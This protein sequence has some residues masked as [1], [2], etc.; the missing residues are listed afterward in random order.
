MSDRP[1]LP[2]DD[3]A[4]PLWS[5]ERLRT[6]R[7][8]LPRGSRLEHFPLRRKLKNYSTRDFQADL[9]AGS[10]VAL[11]DF[12]QGMAYALIA[13]LPFQHG[14]YAS[15]I[16]AV[17]GPL[18]A[19]SRFLMLGP[20]NAIAVLSLSAFMGL[21]F[22][23]DEVL[24]AMPLLLV[25]VG[26]ILIA[27]AFAGAAKLIRYVSRS[28]VTG[29]IT[30]A[31]FLIIGNQLRHVLGYSIP[32]ASTFLE[33]VR[34]TVGALSDTRWPSVALAAGALLLY[35]L[36]TRHARALPAV[37]LT[38]AAAAGAHAGMECWFDGWQVR[39]LDAIA[40]GH[41]PLSLPPPDAELIRLLLPVAFAIAFLSVLESS[42]IAKTLAA[43][44]GDRIDLDQ[45]LLSMGAAN[46]GCAFGSGMP[47]SGSLTR[48]VLNFTGGART[49]ASSMVSGAILTV[50]VLTLGRF[51]GRIP[52]PALAVLVIAIGASLIHPRN[53]RF[54]LGSTNSDAA[55]FLTTFVAG[56]LLPLDTA[57]YLG[58]ALSIALFLRK[59]S[60]PQLKE[61]NFTEE[62]ELAE[63][64]RKEQRPRP[65]IAIL[66][67]EGDLFFA[68]SEI[69][70][71][72]MRRLADDPAIRIFIL[73]LKNARHL[74]ATCA[75]AIEEFTN[76]LRASG[77]DLIV[78]GARREIHRVV[79][80][81]GLLEVLGPGNFFLYTPENPN[82][83]T[84][85]ALKRSQQLLGDEEAG[86]VLL[87]NR[88]P[89][90]DRN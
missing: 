69:F 40:P 78:S 43:Q 8:N 77:R 5:L 17:V 19:S 41:W 3:K 64:T 46:L 33:V 65:H 60:I 76:F 86:I 13:G 80:D 27:G 25:M 37:A 36:L 32:P 18:F 81:S 68:A 84:R 62:G 85:S 89:N 9:R 31:A 67:V 72:Q 90:E 58:A 66:H 57:I 83:S 26:L 28:V 50:G 44:A 6:I 23:P 74:D 52:I 54:V 16:A 15:A 20:T 22:G 75:M 21:G 38:L 45:Q 49:P 4:R 10:N 2:P 63:I 73:R 24:R 1:E 34:Q 82:L 88:S 51:I 39:T 29:Y 56:L 47:I 79:R 55:V 87:V 70:M 7:E 42:A 53:I 30:A 71:D 35:L 11:L 48:S 61:Y 12:P 14:I 59:A